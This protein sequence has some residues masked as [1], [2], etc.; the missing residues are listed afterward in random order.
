MWILKANWDDELPENVIN[1]WLQIREDLQRVNMFSLPRSISHS[2]NST[3]ELHGFSDASIHA[4]AAV[5][6]SRIEVTENRFIIRLLAAKSKVAPIKQITLP[7]L[8]LCGAQLLS[9]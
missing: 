7:R 2:T 3:L 5:V 6:Y 4:Y 9:K 1:K 8:E